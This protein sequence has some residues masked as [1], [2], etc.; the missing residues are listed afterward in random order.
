MAT[1]LPELLL[2]D[3]D[4]WGAWLEEHHAS[5]DGVRL[6]LA[7]KDA[8][9]AG[10]APTQLAYADALP[11]ALCF[12]WIDGQVRSRDGASYAIR[13]G[14]RRARS[15]WSARNVGIATDLIQRGLMR[16][17]GLAEVERA[18]ADGRWEAA[19][20]GSASI[21]V[22]PELAEALAASPVAAA[23]FGRL[24]AQNRY[25]ILFRLANA[26][27]AETRT[28]NV[29]KYIEMLERGEPPGPQKRSLLED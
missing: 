2:P 9:A 27:R 16:P 3:A 26:K 7:K 22:P 6:V 21:E 20:R 18:K 19:Y 29:A 14:P 24:S 10:S 13:Y 8:L 25:A 17:A 4:A 11:P 23:A 1:E 28:R 15:I 5:C 12:G